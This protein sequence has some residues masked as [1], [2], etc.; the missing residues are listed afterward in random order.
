MARGKTKGA[1]SFVTIDMDTLSK[2]F[3]PKG[4]IPVSRTWLRTVNI[5][6]QT[7]NTIAYEATH[8]INPEDSIEMTLIA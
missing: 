6:V 4:Q 8:K 1:T 7:I 5:D 3:G 2:Y